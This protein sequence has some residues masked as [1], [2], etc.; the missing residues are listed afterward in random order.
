MSPA[1]DPASVLL[2]RIRAKRA[3]TEKAKTRRTKPNAA[4]QVENT[5]RN[6]IITTK[7]ITSRN[8]R[9]IS[10]TNHTAIPAERI[11]KSILLI[12]GEKVRLD[13]DLDR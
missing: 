2:D 10:I 12:R 11:E 6:R 5:A 8:T 13:A 7:S 3:S 4:S 9:S 1:D